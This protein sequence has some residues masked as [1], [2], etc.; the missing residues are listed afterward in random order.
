M[1]DGA[2]PWVYLGH[3]VLR[4]PSYLVTYHNQGSNHTNTLLERS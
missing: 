3:V 4:Q 1:E 2:V